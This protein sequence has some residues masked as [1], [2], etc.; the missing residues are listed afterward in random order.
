[1]KFASVTSPLRTTMLGLLASTSL[2]G[3]ASA[4]RTDTVATVEAMA[5]ELRAMRARIDMLEREVTTLRAPK[6]AAPRVAQDS[7][8]TVSPSRS[9]TG[10]REDALA[11]INSGQD[12]DPPIMNAPQ[13]SLDTDR[14][15]FPIEIFGQIQ[16][17]FAYTGNPGNRIDTVDLGFNGTARRL[18]FGLRG[19]V[20]GDFNYNL[21]FNL[22]REVVGY[23]DI[24]LS[25]E[26]EGKP[27]SIKI[28]HH[29]PFNSL[30]NMTS[31]RVTSFVERSTAN[32]A[33]NFNRR[34]GASFG[35]VNKSGDLRFNAGVF[36][37]FINNSA[38]N[39]E[40]SLAARAVWSPKAY[41]GLFH[42]AG[43]YQFR[44][45]PSQEQSFL[46][47]ARPYTQATSIRFVG[48]GPAT[49]TG[50]FTPGI[51][52]RGDQVFGV[53]LAGIFGPFHFASEAHYVAVNAISPTDVLT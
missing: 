46:Y 26:P 11:A 22:A 49:T 30:E 35:L 7:A 18:T 8:D 39:S 15:Q 6:P 47:R 5:A 13:A 43:S 23:Q 34:I 12:D 9:E 28:G 20:P 50:A 37:G 40:Y 14:R 44:R 51:A 16:Y 42:I 25:W 41:G 53:E 1:M 2:G 38:T 24:S 48:T 52:T 10:S 19:A 45:T 4:Q 27:Y 17:D 29:Y 3:T 36:N 32:D 31:N 21:E 33:F